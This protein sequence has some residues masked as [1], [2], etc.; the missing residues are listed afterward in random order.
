MPHSGQNTSSTAGDI[1]QTVRHSSTAHA[2]ARAGF[3][4][5]GLVHI[6][7]GWIALQVAFGKGGSAD[8]NGALQRLASEPFGSFLLWFVIVATWALAVWFVVEAVA[9]GREAKDRLKDAAKAVAYAAVGFTAFSVSRGT[10]KNSDKQA[11]SWTAKFLGNGLGV[12]VLVIVALVIVGVGAYFVH[13][14]VTKG[15]E[16]DVTLPAGT[17]GSVVRGLGVFGY[18]AKGVALAVVGVLLA[19]AAFT[20]DAKKAAGIDGALK[21]L[22]DLPAG[23]V[24]LVVVAVGLI[25]YGLY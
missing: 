24:L 5:A 8:Q 21:A 14:G 15:F 18:T 16:K 20:S 22:A 7:I 10:A 2:F 9:P 25:A 23:T 17:T 19:V 4:A 12:T 6:L 11:E 13:K 1:A 3:A